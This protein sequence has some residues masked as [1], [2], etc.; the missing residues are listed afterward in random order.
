M[1][2]WSPNI[3]NIVLGSHWPNG[4]GQQTSSVTIKNKHAET[5]RTFI[6]VLCYFLNLSRL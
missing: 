2:A 6:T 1:W 5:A 3:P 4:A